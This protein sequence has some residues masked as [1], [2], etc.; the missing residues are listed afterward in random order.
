[1]PSY[2]SFSFHQSIYNKVQIFEALQSLLFKS[3]IV[4]LLISF[5]LFLF[6]EEKEVEN[7]LFFI[8]IKGA[9]NFTITFVLLF[10]SESKQ[11]LSA[12]S[13]LSG[14]ILMKADLLS[15]LH[16]YT[17]PSEGQVEAGL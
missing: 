9:A 14:D 1:M 8:I 16:E 13:K 11:F 17:D 2:F 15:N 4:D 6:K 3:K 12:W 5:C 7:L 10:K